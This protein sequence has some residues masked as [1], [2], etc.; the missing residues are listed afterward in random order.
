MKKIYSITGVIVLAILIIGLFTLLKNSESNTKAQ[1]NKTLKTSATPKITMKEGM[2][3][4][5]LKNNIVRCE[6]CFRRCV[7]RPNKRGLCGVRENKDGKLYSLVYR[8]PCAINIDPV[9][10]EPVYHFLPGTNILCIAT[11]GC[12]MR[13]KFCHNWSI[14]QRLPEDVPSEYIP[15]EVVVSLAK[16]N[17][18]MGVSF[19]YSE[20]AVFYE[21]MLEISKLAKESGLKVIMHT[22]GAINPEPLKELLKYLDAVTVDLK[23]FTEK[24]YTTAIPNGSLGHVLEIIKIVKKSGV[25]LELVNLVIPKMND[26]PDDIKK[27]CLW[28]KENLGC[29]VPLHFSRFFPTHKMTHLPPTPIST[30]EM[31]ERIATDC[32][33]NYVTIG[34]VPGHEKNST[35]CPGCKKKLIH[36]IHFEVLKNDVIQGRCR[37]CGQEIPGVWM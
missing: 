23:G 17:N 29:D 27:M 1:E 3:Y 12:G 26:N 18:C 4:Q 25:W 11:V 16:R 36:R 32:G 30:L 28:I 31:A 10:K 5:K 6:L 7:I 2:F 13:C 35:F 21:Y 15:P 24:F 8:K 20:P 37:Y 19:T 9:E 22:S 14:S 34:N 33:L